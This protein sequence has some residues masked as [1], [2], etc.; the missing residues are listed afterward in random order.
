M[1]LIKRITLD[2]C[3]IDNGLLQ[4]QASQSVKGHSPYFGNKSCTL[5]EHCGTPK[6]LRE[7]CSCSLIVC[8]LLGVVSNL[9]ELHAPA[10]HCQTCYI[11]T[12][13]AV[14]RK[15]SIYLMDAGLLLQIQPCK[16]LVEQWTG[17]P[18]ALETSLYATLIQ[19][20]SPFVLVEYCQPCSVIMKRMRDKQ[21]RFA[22]SEGPYRVPKSASVSQQ[23]W[24]SKFRA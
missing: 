16:L 10:R 5:N 3:G 6:E 17:C 2:Y 24:I 8:F 12:R 13:S 21:K 20:R 23:Q 15:K 11:R 19:K 7:L 14:C 4:V 22:S 1:K 9:A 18:T